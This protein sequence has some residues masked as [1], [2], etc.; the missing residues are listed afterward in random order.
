MDAFSYRIN[1]LLGIDDVINVLAG[2]GINRPVDDKERISKMFQNADLVVS[3]WHG[4]R[5][6]GV[7]RALTDWCYCCYLSDLAVHKDFQRKGIGKELIALTRKQI[8]DGCMLLLLS[9][10]SAM[11]YYPRINMVKLSNAFIFHRTD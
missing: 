10:P 3:A 4:D 7:S 6:I 11:E 8:G 2:S 9:A 5:L 1:G